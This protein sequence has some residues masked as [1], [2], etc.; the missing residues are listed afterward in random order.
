MSPLP[1]DDD[2]D[3]SESDDNTLMLVTLLDIKYLDRRYSIPWPVIHTDHSAEENLIRR[4]YFGP[5]PCIHPTCFAEGNNYI[6]LLLCVPLTVSFLLL[7]IT[8]LGSTWVGRCSSVL[9]K[10]CNSRIVTSLNELMRLAWL[11]SYHFKKYVPQCGSLLTAYQL[12]S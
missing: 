1:S 9:L 11:D 5:N 7:A 2:S 3:S 6:S 8:F 4:H 10:D 12:M